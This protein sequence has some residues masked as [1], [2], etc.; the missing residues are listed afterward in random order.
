MWWTESGCQKPV[1]VAVAGNGGAAG[2]VVVAG[3]G[4]PSLASVV[5]ILNEKGK[6]ERLGLDPT[7]VLD[8]GLG[9]VMIGVEEENGGFVNEGVEEGNAALAIVG[10]EEGRRERGGGGRRRERN[11]ATNGGRAKMG[12]KTNV[13][14]GLFL[15]ISLVIMS[16]E[17]T[18]NR[19]LVEIS[20][21]EKA[22]TD[23]RGGNCR[24]NCCRGYGFGGGCT[25][26]CSYLGEPVD[27]ET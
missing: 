22:N 12:S 18:A 4:S 17:V 6:R 19:N 25:R 14:L 13:F 24:Y 20:T 7:E 1:V 3:G 10:G 16:S 15:V 5:C 11:G 21:T 9:V 8:A 26:C 2:V 27:I 23:Q